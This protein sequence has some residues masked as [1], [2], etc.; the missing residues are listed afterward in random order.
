L[1][2][3]SV[4]PSIVDSLPSILPS[5]PVETIMAKVLHCNDVVPGCKFEARG[6]SEEE[7]IAEYAD[8]L[9]TAHNMPDISD[10]ILAMVSRAILEEV[11]WRGRA[12]GRA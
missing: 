6:K 5:F 7:V 11:R 12:A 4:V 1:T 2:K 10:E 3:H 9:A 8:H